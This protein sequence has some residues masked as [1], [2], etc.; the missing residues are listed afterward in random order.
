[1][2]EMALLIAI[3]ISNRCS[4]TE[5]CQS[6]S[7]LPRRAQVFT[8]NISQS[9]CPLLQWKAHCST[10]R[11]SFCDIYPDTCTLLYHHEDGDMLSLPP[12][13]RR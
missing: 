12:C 9:N 8:S 5:L 11:H 7:A 6:L 13:D 1:M 3:P 10:A 4:C 2:E